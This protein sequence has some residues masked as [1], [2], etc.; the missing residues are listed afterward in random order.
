M[1]C[2]FQRKNL[3]IIQAAGRILRAP[4]CPTCMSTVSL[5]SPLPRFSKSSS[6]TH[7]S[8]E[9]HT[10]KKRPWC[11]GSVWQCHDPQPIRSLKHCL[12]LLSAHH[13]C[14][15]TEGRQ[16]GSAGRPAVIVDLQNSPALAPPTPPGRAGFTPSK[17]SRPATNQILKEERPPTCAASACG[18]STDDA[19]GGR[20]RLRAQGGGLAR[21]TT[22]VWPGT[23]P[24]LRGAG[25]T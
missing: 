23:V 3:S 20:I 12:Y 8:S 19:H 17:Y 10:G 21:A 22:D 15:F 4:T 11:R 16:R 7:S 13:P 24:T 25:P 14:P 9:K 18:I 6:V 5:N 1:S 2:S